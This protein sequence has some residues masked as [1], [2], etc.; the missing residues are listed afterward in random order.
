MPWFLLL[1]LR[2]EPLPL[3]W[4][5]PFP[6]PLPLPLPEPFP[7]SLPEPF[8]LPLPEAFMANGDESLTLRRTGILPDI[9][10]SLDTCRFGRAGPARVRMIEGVSWSATVSS[11]SRCGEEGILTGEHA[12]AARPKGEVRKVPEVDRAPG[13]SG[14]KGS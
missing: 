6:L 11:V 12:L 8:E 7:L 13:I 4:P 10:K 9:T 14:M 3:P 1:L 2:L 5:E